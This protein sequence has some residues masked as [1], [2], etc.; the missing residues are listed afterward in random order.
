M[1]QRFLYSRLARFD[2]L[3]PYYDIIASME[4]DQIKEE[5]DEDIEE[6]EDL[7][8]EESEGFDVNSVFL[9]DT[10]YIVDAEGLKKINNKKK[11]VIDLG[12][13]RFLVI[14]DGKKYTP[15]QLEAM[16]DEIFRAIIRE[17]DPD[18]GR[19]RGIKQL[20]GVLL[21]EHYRYRRR[22]EIYNMTGI[23]DPH[24]SKLAAERYRN[25]KNQKKNNDL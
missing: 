7:E 20:G 22:R 6:F 21:E 19:P 9:E 16:T 23:A 24:L 5:D 10:N 17:I 18:T 4:E 25:N 11:T 8:E 3:G 1:T 2:S 14:E 12:R 13:D 15:L